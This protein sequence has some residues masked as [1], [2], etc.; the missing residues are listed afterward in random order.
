MEKLIYVVDDEENIC[1]ILEYNLIKNGYKVKSFRDGKSFLESFARIKPNLVILDLMLPD[2][3]GFDVCREIKKKSD[4]PVII[5]SAKSEELDKVLG[6]ELGADDYMVKPFGVRE[7][8]ARVKNI[9]RRVKDS[10][11]KGSDRTAKKEFIFK[12]VKLAIDETR[13]EVLLDSEKIHLNPKEFQIVLLLLKNLD[14][15][16]PRMELV[17]TVWGDDYYGDTR[18]LD[19][20]IRRIRRKMTY[21]EFGK[22]FIK[23]VHGYGYKITNDI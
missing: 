16:I 11:D 14:R 23:T 12:E 3:D 4:V 20:H 18:T 9:F 19:V 8:I 17:K 15:L 2:L 21:K 7:L 6:L 1:E 13:H 22:R 5:L 10:T